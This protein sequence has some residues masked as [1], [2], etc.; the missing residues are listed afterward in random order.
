MGVKITFRKKEQ[1]ASKNVLE[2]DISCGI[3]EW[4]F[5]TKTM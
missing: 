4:A 5:K 3:S 2:R 1:K